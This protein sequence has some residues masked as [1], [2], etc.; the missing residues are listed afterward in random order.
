MVE[1][2]YPAINNNVYNHGAVLVY[3]D[4]DGAWSQVPLT[5]YYQD[6]IKHNRQFR[7]HGA[8]RFECLK[9]IVHGMEHDA[10][11]Q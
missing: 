6:Q 7:V 11:D 5:Y 10:R 3:M 4:V 8:F 9:S 1:I 2:D